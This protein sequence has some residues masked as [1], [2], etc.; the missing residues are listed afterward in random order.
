VTGIWTALVIARW[1][2]FVAVAG[3]FGMALFP[4]YAPE[5]TRRAYMA[6]VATRRLVMIGALLALASTVGWAAATLANMAGDSGAIWEG[7]A[8]RSFLLDTSFGA[9]WIARVVLA[10]MLAIVTIRGLRPTT[11]V[12]ALSAALLISQAWVG[13]VASLAAP[14]RLGVTVAYALHVLGAGAWFGGLVSLIVALNGLTGTKTSDRHE[15]QNLLERFSSVGLAAVA[16]IVLGGAINTFAHGAASPAILL[17]SDWGRALLVKLALV[18]GMLL[19]ACLNRFVLM[20]RLSRGEQAAMPA[21]R[22]SV[23]AE[24]AL[25]LAVLALTATL[26]GLDPSG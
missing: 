25:G 12:A 15:G 10:A 5:R 24:H 8:W 17:T 9:A 7:E 3:L 20:P 13:H 18:V 6:L 11:T 1:L 4:I 14:L 19:L 16:A 21:I 23:I 26:G 22:R 2:N